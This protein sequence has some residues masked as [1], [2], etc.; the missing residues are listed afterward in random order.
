MDIAGPIRG[1]QAR[2]TILVAALV[3]AGISM[4]LEVL[5]SDPTS[6]EV[7]VRVTVDLILVAMATWELR[8][9]LRTE[10]LAMFIAGA[11]GTLSLIDLTMGTSL[12][13]FDAGST[14]ALQI[15]I[16]VIYVATRESQTPGPVVI[17][18]SL[19]AAYS[20]AVVLVG[21]LPVG[22]A[23]SILMLGGPGQV[24]VIWLVYRLI[25][26]LRAASATEA[27]HA[28]IQ[29][30]LAR[31]SQALLS[32]RTD[33]PLNTA[34]VALLDATEAD[35]AYIDVNRKGPDGKLMWEIVAEA[36]SAAYPYKEEG[37][38]SGD[39]AGLETVEEAMRR[40][41][42][43]MLMTSELEEPLRSKYEAEG[44][45]AELMAPILIGSR[46]I[47]TLGYTDHVRQGQWTEIEIEGLRR[48]AEM[49]G[50]YWEREGARE[51]LMELAQA[52]DRF[53]ATVSHELRTP[54]AAVVGFAG[55]LA[56]N[57]ENHTGED[58]AEMASL[59]YTQAQEL[60]HL[61]DDLLTSE[62]A[63]SGNL[64]VHPTEI[65][66]LE[67]CEDLVSSTSGIINAEIKGEEITAF[68]DTLRTRQILRNLLTNAVRY[69][70]SV[71]EAEVRGINGQA[72]V[73][74]RDNGEGVTDLDAD[75]IFDPYARTMGTNTTPDSVGLGLSVARQLARLMDGD[76]VYRHTGEWTEFELTLPM[77]VSEPVTKPEPVH[78]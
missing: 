44:I 64:T 13:A 45:K 29:R 61:V 66:L 17:F 41:E 69:G 65:S 36:K 63:A 37:L 9:G 77:A 10:I 57:P 11:Y 72:G 5:L 39:Y 4:F 50:S 22:Q 42:A 51:G 46:W 19:I 34:L 75:R 53:I 28:R 60:T 32:G 30:A 68:A 49:V 2:R 48:A 40:G 7:A 70:G 20:L 58:L 33:E 76:L 62:R 52:K 59:I 38:V 78:T 27:T 16:A 35:Y 12:S 8:H 73:I 71:I 43:A 14:L 3:I 56:Q 26:T 23:S 74:I 24:V 6:P 1:L 31:C 18:S 25:G 67:E 15:L 21:D 54:L 55:E 47:G